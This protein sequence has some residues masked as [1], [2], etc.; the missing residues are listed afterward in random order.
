MTFGIFCTAF[1]RKKLLS[2]FQVLKYRLLLNNL[3]IR[4]IFFIERIVK[5]WHR[6]PR[7]VAESP[8]LEGL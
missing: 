2:I 3:D 7:K 4:R 5:H 6:L 1:K 8:S